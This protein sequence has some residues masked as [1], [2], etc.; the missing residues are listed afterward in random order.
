MLRTFEECIDS[1]SNGVTLQFGVSSLRLEAVD[2]LTGVGAL[3][4][5]SPKYFKITNSGYEFYEQLKAPRIY[6]LKE[7]WFRVIW[8]RVIV[9]LAAV[10]SGLVAM[11]RWL[12]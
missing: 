4:E 6:W 12:F 3:W 2:L 9:P 11:L 1:E 8:L 7:N 10:I 5:R